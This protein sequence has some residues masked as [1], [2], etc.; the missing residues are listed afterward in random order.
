M[1]EWKQITEPT[2]ELIE[3][4]DQESLVDAT[5]MRGVD[6]GKLYMITAPWK[7]GVRLFIDATPNDD[8]I[9]AEELEQDYDDSPRCDYCGKGIVEFETFAYAPYCSEECRAEA[10]ATI[11]PDAEAETLAMGPDE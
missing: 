7:G 9:P 4:Q 6:T 10:Q 5:Y 8:T 1:P 3:A 2:E 11:E